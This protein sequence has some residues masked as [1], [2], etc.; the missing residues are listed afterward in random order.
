MLS[1]NIEPSSQV[2]QGGHCTVQPKEQWK[3]KLPYIRVRTYIIMYVWYVHAWFWGS[4]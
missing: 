3:S 2:R 1:T 4:E